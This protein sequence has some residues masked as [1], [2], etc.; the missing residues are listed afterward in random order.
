[1]IAWLRR[2][3]CVAGLLFAT[4][5]LAQK[6]GALPVLDDRPTPQVDPGGPSAAVTC[7]AF[8][9][10]GESLYAAGL[11]KVV[12]VWT[13]REGR[14]VL[15]RSFRVPVGPGSLGAI[16][17]IAL[18]PDGAWLAVAGRAP[19]RGEAGFRT[20]GV[21]VDS[22]ALGREQMLDAGVIYVTQ[23]AN[24]AGGRVL[25]GHRG[26]V[27][28]IEFAPSQAGK[29]SLLVSAAT[30]RDGAKRFGGLRLWDVA[31]GALLAERNDLPAKETR[32]GLAVW[33]TGPGARQVRVAV[34]WPEDEGAPML[35]LWDT[36]PGA[37]P[38]QRWGNDRFPY[39]AALLGQ[40]RD[41]AASILCGG[42]GDGTGRLRQWNLGNERD[43]RVEIA[44][45]VTFGPA[46]S[47][48]FFLPV[49]LGLEPPRAD[50]GRLAAVI[51]RPEE[52]PDGKGEDLRLAV[53]DLAAGRV[54]AT[55]P[56]PGSDKSQLPVV[57][58]HR[59][60][61]AVAATGDHAV[62]IFS[63]EDLRAGKSEPREIL[64]AAAVAVR[65]VAFADAGRGLWLSED[66]GAKFPAGG[67][68]FDLEKRQLRANDRADLRADAPNLNVDGWAV[69]IDADRH[70]VQVRQGARA[71]P[72]VRLPGKDEFVTAAALRPATKDVPAVL[73]V[74][75]MERD[76]GRA[77]IR[78]FDPA[79][80]K[81]FRQLSG[82]LQPIRGL[83][84]SG[85]RP[86]L[87]S[88]ADDQ[89]VCVWTLA[90]V[91]QTIGQLR[92]LTVSAS[93]ERV[94]VRRVNADGPAG[95]AAGDVIETLGSGEGAK[96]IK[97]AADF[98]L[99]V[100]GRKPGD[101]LDV[102]VRG[103]GA[104]RLAIERGVD[105]RKPL[106]SLLLL[107]T[108]AAP[109]WIGWSPAGPYD[110]SNPAA[111]ARLGWHTNTGD[112][113]APVSYVAARTH[114]ARY[115]REG[116]LGYLAAEAELPRALERWLKDHPN[117]PT[118]PALR[119]QAPDGVTAVGPAGTYLT[120]QALRELTLGI[121]E[122]YELDDRHVVRWQLTR[123][124]GGN[125]AAG[126]AELTGGAARAGRR[127]KMSLESVAWSRGDYWLRILL[128]TRE[129]GPEVGRKSL[130]FRF[131][132]PAPKV[133]LR[134]DGRPLAGTEQQPLTVMNDM[135][136]AQVAVEAAPGQRISLSFGQWRNGE[137]AKEPPPS[138][139]VP[140]TA[141]VAQGFKLSDG[142]N[143]L[144]VRAVNKSA[145]EG[146][147][148][149]EAATAELWVRYKAPELPP[150]FAELRLDPRPEVTRAAG[151]E[152]L[153]VS[154][155]SVN[156]TGSLEGEGPLVKAE[157][158]IGD[159]VHSFLPPAE[160]RTADL[161]ATL[162]DLKPG[163][164]VT[165]RLRARSKASPEGVVERRVVY[166][167][168][169]PAIS[170]DPVAGP[171]VFDDKVTLTGLVRPAT[172]DAFTLTIRVTDSAGRVTTPKVDVN[173]NAGEWKVEV[174]LA[175]GRNT[176]ETIVANKWRG[177]HPVGAG[178][179]LSYR[180]RPRITEFPEQIEAAGTNR[181]RLALAVRGPADRP[182]TAVRVN[183]KP[184]E[185]K[186]GS[187]LV[188]ADNATWPVELPEVVVGDGAKEPAELSLRAVTEEGES[189]PV[190]VRVIRKNEPRLPAVRFVSPS[191]DTTSRRPEVTLVYRVE[192]ARPLERV[193][194]TGG[195]E[196]Y[197]K[198]LRGVRAQDEV[199]AFQEQATVALGDGPN[200][201][202]LVAFNAD[203]R[204]PAAKLVVSYVE[205]AVLIRVDG[206]ELRGEA[207]DVERT[208]E[209]SYGSTGDLSFPPAD[210]SLVWLVGRVRWSDPKAAA[211]DDPG[212]SVSITVRDC[213]QLPVALAPR[214]TG[215]E[216]NVRRFR[217]PIFL[218]G[219]QNRVRIDVPT[220]GQQELSRREFEIA[221]A[222]P[223]RKQRLHLLVV[224]VDVEDAEA[225]KDR[226]L[227][228]LSAERAGRPRALQGAFSRN[229]PFEQ[230]YLHG[231][232][233]GEVERSTIETQLDRIN[234]VI[235]RSRKEDGWLN[236]VVLVYYQG[237]D[238]V[239]PG[240]RERWLKTSKN[241]QYKGVA[242][243]EFALPCHELPR[244]PGAQL[245]LLN[246][247]G[248][249]DALAKQHDWGGDPTTG[250]MRYA[251][252][253]PS[254]A[255]DADPTLLRVLQDAV[256]QK[257]RLGDVVHLV[258]EAFDRRAEAPK[259]VV[260][261][262]VDQESR[263]ISRPAK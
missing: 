42:F 220:V 233:A 18:S 11:D 5:A 35:R 7:V 129:G 214:G 195:K 221:C 84:F 77:L 218:I 164:P 142:L 179:A 200:T 241:F 192:S 53:A 205:S 223:S 144:V 109:E 236:D 48:R 191:A 213:R 140:G 188:E 8:S 135:L 108:G 28:A 3:G 153:V 210:R 4:V 208:L 6:P 119:L 225:L 256:K 152:L 95:L 187:R 32:P 231:V 215:E 222:N 24:P 185:F 172:Q 163:E 132:P 46:G 158:A 232:L 139:E 2:A 234:D 193:K 96:S 147:E 122:D 36:A 207:D 242:P 17:A 240:K 128:Y 67:W 91:R 79:T 29:P 78:L 83:A 87:A 33:H 92:G 177:E 254:E 178:L 176:I 111:E 160:S 166:H 71:L 257:S 255:R 57:A 120:R 44:G 102:G 184:V 243:Q 171:D 133:E 66:G 10:D 115:F 113:A 260:L 50:G 146:H 183:G 131:Q 157:W 58:L 189:Q 169:L 165:I 251:C 209:P 253:N 70:G 197:E 16:N 110:F 9:G 27:R 181:V 244:V 130:V 219:E 69:T 37:E 61:V 41:G 204:S 263:T 150:R 143:R 116:I 194:I 245:M 97:S 73:A 155:P 173:L 26:E 19:I 76:A 62:R 248:P 75:Y 170:P 136:T 117:A 54:L 93:D 239:I 38:M 80:G 199:Y 106:F 12:R 156:L 227:D 202:E 90:D 81:P 114:S 190:S 250:F 45:S 25:R 212:L 39:I 246:V 51:L 168:P 107:R 124:D 94:I 162:N 47:A 161:R 64:G 211:L 31:T 125:I 262:D 68:A 198:D 137:P 134:A 72:P 98:L 182:P 203:G 230:C 14:F 103:K 1:M 201:L 104:V 59:R 175:P 88:V 65:Q 40:G 261:L 118:Q 259:P 101:R 138:A 258:N 159:E 217:A 145:S 235:V 105:E 60:H 149:D 20:D 167:P 141:E 216:A 86:L 237:E 21:V 56:L 252:V 148:D 99:A 180:R 55:V 112:A 49:A 123:A 15:Q 238:V 247:A 224:G 126:A 186:V 196:Q 229:P 85:A 249:P 13:W 82:H 100:A 22:A 154:R 74:A 63:V 52:R 30:E 174:P 43:T 121:N 34:A 226:V 127:W 206:I 228:A 89:T 23:T 151:H